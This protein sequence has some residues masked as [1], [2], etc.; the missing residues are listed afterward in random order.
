VHDL[1]KALIEG[2]EVEGKR[3][4][5]TPLQAPKAPSNSQAA[6]KPQAPQAPHMPGMPAPGTPPIPPQLL[7]LAPTVTEVWTGVKLGTAVL[8]KVNRPAG[9]LTTYCKPTSTEEPHPSLFEI[10]P[11]Y[12]LKKP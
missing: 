4:I 7:K 12:K 5:L 8:T 2:L 6:T 10:P 3:Y 1:G 9:E 11:G